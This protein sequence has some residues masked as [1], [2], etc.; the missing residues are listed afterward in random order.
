MF[1]GI[2]FREILQ[3]GPMNL[4]C[5]EILISQLLPHFPQA[6]ELNHESNVQHRLKKT[7]SYAYHFLKN[8]LIT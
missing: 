1:C 4:M 6:N 2:N 8:M 7:R 5:L 3:E